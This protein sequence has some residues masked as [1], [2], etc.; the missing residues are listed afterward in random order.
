MRLRSATYDEAVIIGAVNE[1]IRLHGSVAAEVHHGGLRVVRV[2][3]SVSDRSGRQQGQLKP[4]A[5]VQGKLHDLLVIDDLSHG[6]IL[7]LEQRRRAGD[8]YVLAYRAD[9]HRHV[10]AEPVVD[11]CLDS[12]AYGGAESGGGHRNGIHARAQ[13]WRPIESI[14]IGH[15]VE[16]GSGSLIPNGD[17][18]AG[19]GGAGRVCDLT[20]D[21]GA[22][23]LR[24]K[25]NS[26]HTKTECHE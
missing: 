25:W 14:R 16:Q 13:L 5:S 8:Y 1:E 18:C 3:G 15:A 20:R 19:N 11:S 7:R 17:A 6:G 2:V 4:T 24:R 21:A 9:L 10:D 26:G 22:F 12:L 23:L